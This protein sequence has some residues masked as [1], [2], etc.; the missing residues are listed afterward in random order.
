MSD[1]KRF[2]LTARAQMRPL[3]DPEV[4]NAALEA[5]LDEEDLVNG[6]LAFL[7]CDR[8]GHLMQPILVSDVPDP[9]GPEERW[10]AM[11]WAIALCEMVGDEHA[12]PLALV[13]AI[14]REAGPVCDADREWHQV[15]IDA[16]AEAEVPLIGVHVATLAEA[17]A[18]PTAAPRPAGDFAPPRSA[19]SAA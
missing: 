18:L 9:A 16:C 5:F 19:E 14:V 17:V 12:G 6:G 10:A 3:H 15:A 11:R 7:F 1:N 8:E 2:D 4:A 13:L